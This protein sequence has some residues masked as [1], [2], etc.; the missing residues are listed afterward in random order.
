MLTQDASKP[1]LKSIRIYCTLSYDGYSL[2]TDTVTL[3]LNSC[4]HPGV[5]HE[6]NCLQC[7]QKKGDGDALLVRED[8]LYHLIA[9]AEPGEANVG[10]SISRETCRTKSLTCPTPMWAART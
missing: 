10:L 5:D 1:W 4:S 8:G 9:N 7:G 2:D 6:G 3:G